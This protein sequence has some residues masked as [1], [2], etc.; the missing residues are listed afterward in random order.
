MWVFGYGSLM[1][2]PNFAFTATSK[3]RLS[4]YHRALCIHST[5]YR[6]TLERPGLVFGLNRGGVCD[7]VAFEVAPEHA[8]CVLGNLRERELIYGVYREVRR[9]ITLADPQRRDVE[10]VTY[11]A[12]RA[13]PSF[14]GCTS[15]ARQSEI[16]R[17]ARGIAGSNLAYVV[18]TLSHLRALGLRDRGT[19]RVGKMAAAF[20][21]GCEQTGMIEPARV[22]ALSAAWRQRTAPRRLLKRCDQTRFQHRAGMWSED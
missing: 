10:A 1:W 2:N 5:H 8:S 21:L 13:H 11:V 9:V 12:E 20:A 4:G 14:A 22:T 3:A 16:I 18:N 17:S 6:G 7:G 15:A 19:E